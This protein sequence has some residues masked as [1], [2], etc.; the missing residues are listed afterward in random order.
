[1]DSSRGGATEL[2]LKVGDTVE[3]SSPEIGALTNTV[4]AK[5]SAVETGSLAAA[6]R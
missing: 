1:M 2:F 4:V 3:V 5:G 6:A